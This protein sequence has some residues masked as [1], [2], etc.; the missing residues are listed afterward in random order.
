MAGLKVEIPLS[1]A[2]C[3]FT[4]LCGDAVV[5][6][7]TNTCTHTKIDTGG[8]HKAGDTCDSSFLLAEKMNHRCVHLNTICCSHHSLNHHCLDSL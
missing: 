4:G 5:A 8:T 2:M 7:I 6:G 3:E 1:P